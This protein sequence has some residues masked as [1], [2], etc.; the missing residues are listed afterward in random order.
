MRLAL[1][2]NCITSLFTYLEIHLPFKRPVS[3]SFT[4]IYLRITYLF[5]EVLHLSVEIT[6]LLG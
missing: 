6:P 5:V 2:V 1:I 4:L 3:D